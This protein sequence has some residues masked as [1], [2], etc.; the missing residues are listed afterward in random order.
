MASTAIKL[1][2]AEEEALGKM[3]K[4]GL[5]ANKNEA[6]R[7]AIVKYASDLGVLSPA[8]LW[9]KINRHK[10][11]KVTPEQLKK[12]LEALENEAKSNRLLN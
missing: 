9:D 8:M 7:A 11:R 5:V 6:A 4:I 12:E 3:V 10:R 1:E 2:K